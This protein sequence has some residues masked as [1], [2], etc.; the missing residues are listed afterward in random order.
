MHE[1]IVQTFYFHYILQKDQFK[2]G[3]ENKDWKLVFYSR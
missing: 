3:K 1:I 2:S